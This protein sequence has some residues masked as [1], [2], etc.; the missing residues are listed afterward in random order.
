MKEL[1]EL[2]FEELSLKQKLGMVYSAMVTSEADQEDID[3]VEELIRNHSLGAIWIQW[4]Y[5]GRDELLAMVKRVADY[6]ILVITDA[7]NGIMD[8]RIGQQNP[9]AGTGREDLAYTFGK[10][11]GVTAKKMGYTMV[12]NPMLDLNTDGTVRSLHWDKREVARIAAAEARGMHD[13]GILTCAKHFPSPIDDEELDS[14]M[15]E[16]FSSQTKEELLD[17]SLYAYRELSKMGLI[18]CMMAGHNKLINIDPDKP[19]SLSKP[20]HDLMRAQGYDGMFITD[21]LCMMGILAKYGLVDCK[22]L[23][24]A[25]GNDLTLVYDK[26]TRFSYAA[27]NDCYERGMIPDDVLDA[28]VKRVLAAQH[29]VMLMQNPI[30]TEITEEDK[31]NFKLITRDSIFARVD[32]GLTTAIPRD[33]RH[34]FV[35]M[36]RNETPFNE[37]KVDVDTFSNGWHFPAK[38]SEKLRELFPNSEIHLIHQFPTQKQMQTVVSDAL[39]YDNIV[40]LTFSEFLAYTGKEHLTQR[41]ISL[42]EAMQKTDRISTLVHFGNPKV[43][44]V[45]PHIP[46]IIVGG[47]T[48]DSVVASLEILAGEHEAKGRET[49]ELNLK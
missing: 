29:K 47:V 31:E 27:F 14:H 11:V 30:H 46:R 36:T 3:F 37:G 49:C 15:V 4:S 1:K 10:I 38:I 48:H 35:L 39:G 21:A 12:C 41:V 23:S 6:P 9:L 13:A 5:P 44:E 24:V 2:K 40:F 32:E 43:L 42:I 7:E 28:A 22:G 16:T 8:Y 17:T 45:L 26:K 20:L 33:G 25:A 19:A 18:D 34:Y